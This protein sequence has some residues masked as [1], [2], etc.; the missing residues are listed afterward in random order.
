[1]RAL[2]TLLC[3]GL[4]AAA[5]PAARKEVVH[6]PVWVQAEAGQ[7]AGRVA[8]DNL[9]IAIGGR[10]AKAEALLGPND[11]LMLVV[12][13]DLCGDLPLAETAKRAVDERIDKLPSNTMVTLLN[14]QNG[15]R[16]LVDPTVERAPVR[17][18]IDAVPVSGKAGLLETIST[19]GALGDSILAKAAVRVAVLYI[20][21]SDVSNYRED[22]TNPTINWSDSG[23][24]SRRFRD[25]LVRERISKIDGTLAGVET[26][27]FIVHVAYRTDSLNQAYQTGLMTLAATTGGASYF[28]RSQSEV[29]DT[30][31]KV[32]EAIGSHYSLRAPLPALGSGLLNIVMESPGRTLHWR[33]R[34]SVGP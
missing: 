24:I 21:D 17:A 22:F 11:D 4:A 16:V 27:M 25:G 33:N 15:L 8:P 28:C 34:I 5:P 13:T 20:T 18:A 10:A 7:P 26:P 9:K 19:V 30:V 12:V 29:A 23:D 1:M 6:I 3:A 31:G 14:S 2:I 32:F